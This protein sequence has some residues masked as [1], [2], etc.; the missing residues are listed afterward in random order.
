[1][2]RESK[3]HYSWIICAVSA[4]LLFCTHGYGNSVL[5]AFIPLL[6]E[7]G[8]SGTQSSALVTI[9]TAFTVLGMFFMTRLY[10]R[11]SLKTGLVLCCAMVSAAFVLMGMED[12]YVLYVIGAVLIGLGAGFGTTAPVSLLINK[13]FDSLRTTAFSVCSAGSAVSAMLLPP[14]IVYIAEKVSVAAAFFAVGAI[15]AAITLLFAAFAKN[16]PQEKGLQPYVRAVE[17]SARKSGS[18]IGFDASKRTKG[19]LY[20]MVAITGGVTIATYA[21][22]SV[23]FTTSG[24]SKMTAATCLS[25]GSALMFGAKILYGSAADRIGAYKVSFVS[26]LVIVI[27]AV[28]MCFAPESMVLM[29]VGTLLVYI[30]FPIGTVG[31]PALAADFSDA[32]SYAKVIGNCQLVC[33]L[34]GIALTQFPGMIY[35][36]TGSYRGAFVIAC[37]FHFS[38]LVLL[39]VAYRAL[40]REKAAAEKNKV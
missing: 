9:R 11:I 28:L 14:M 27:G 39:V 21:H 13:W 19:I 4:L 30:G 26:L 22:F 8:Y 20:L 7:M 23:Y 18:A 5:P 32:A 3:F 10:E 31:L 37:F 40:W 33:S 38:A 24:Y 25:I 6:E 2:K 35:D 12:S 36:M 34:G 1:M 17:T 29:Y 16:T 15:A